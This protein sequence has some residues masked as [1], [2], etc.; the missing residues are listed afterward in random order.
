LKV[1]LDTCLSPEAKQQLEAA[2]YDVVWAGDWTEDPGDEAILDRARREARVLVTLD[3]DFG[4]LGVLRGLSH[5]GIIRLVNF[6][7]AQQGRVCLEILAR[8]SDDLT[9]GAIVTAEAGR[10][11]IRRI[12]RRG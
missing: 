12:D 4:E 5:S 7:A 3:K 9:Q 11:R 10:M 8:H 1:L 2:G 6:R